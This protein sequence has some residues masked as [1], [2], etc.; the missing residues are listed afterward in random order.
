MEEDRFK[1]VKSLT[2]EVTKYLFDAGKYEEYI[3]LFE[4]Y[5]NYLFSFREDLRKTLAK[6]PGNNIHKI[7]S[8][9]ILEEFQKTMASDLFPN[10]LVAQR[11]MI[12]QLEEKSKSIIDKEMAKYT[13]PKKD[14][15]VGYVT[16]SGTTNSPG[17]TVGSTLVTGACDFT[18]YAPY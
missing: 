1:E 12:H 15:S 16:V 8:Y 3:R 7:N 6:Q 14:P 13:K 4:L 9:D 18:L 5:N 17:I 2:K 10:I 11:F